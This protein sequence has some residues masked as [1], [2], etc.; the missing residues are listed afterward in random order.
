MERATQIVGNILIFIFRF[1]KNFTVDLFTAIYFRTIELDSKL[2][3]TKTP[4]QRVGIWSL[5]ALVVL[6]GILL[7]IGMAQLFLN[8]L[9]FGM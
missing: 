9:D 4:G 5:I 6:I 8:S 2:Q 3:Q 1:I 7:V